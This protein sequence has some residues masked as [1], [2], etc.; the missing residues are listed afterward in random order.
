MY[1]TEWDV[2]I[3][4]ELKASHETRPGAL[5][6]DKY[7]M[8]LKYNDVNDAHAPKIFIKNNIFCRKPGEDLLVKII[9]KRFL[10]DLN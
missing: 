3:E 10:H 4:S 2:K 9:G 6:Q 7:A 5:V 8:V 1:Q